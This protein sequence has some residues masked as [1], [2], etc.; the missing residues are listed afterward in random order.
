MAQRPSK[1]GL[2]FSQASLEFNTA[3]IVEGLQQQGGTASK[4]QLKLLA[5][6]CKSLGSKDPNRVLGPRD[7]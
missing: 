2:G 4:M 5:R 1:K 6:A 3:G 7:H